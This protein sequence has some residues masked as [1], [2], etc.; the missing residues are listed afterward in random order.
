MAKADCPPPLLDLRGRL[1]E[2]IPSYMAY[3][4]FFQTDLRRRRT[5]M[6]AEQC[7]RFRRNHFPVPSPDNIVV[8]EDGQSSYPFSRSIS[9]VWKFIPSRPPFWPSGRGRWFDR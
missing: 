1:S 3:S 6:Q 5:I 4:D 7:N 9:K 8:N 2:F